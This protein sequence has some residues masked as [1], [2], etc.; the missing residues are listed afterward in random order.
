MSEPILP[1]RRVGIDTWRENVVFLHRDCPVVRAAGFQALA[2]VRVQSNGK[3]LIGVLN[4]VDD[5]G[6]TDSVPHES[7]VVSI[8]PMV[9]RA[10]AT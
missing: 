1:I 5:E 9:A 10:L 8:A 3:T 6:S 7:N 4:V 2:K